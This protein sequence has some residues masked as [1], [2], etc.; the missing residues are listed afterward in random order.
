[1]YFDR[2]VIGVG[3]VVKKM[4]LVEIFLRAF[5]FFSGSVIQPMICNRSPFFVAQDM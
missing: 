4:V 3:F 1:V 5:E 2:E